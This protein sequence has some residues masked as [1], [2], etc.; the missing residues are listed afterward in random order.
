MKITSTEL[1]AKAMRQARKDQ[2]LSKA[3]IADRIGIKQATVSVFEN[4][5][6][7]SHLD[8]LFKWLS[9]LELDLQI[10]R[11]N[12]P[13]DKTQWDQEWQLGCPQWNT[14]LCSG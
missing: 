11:R 7:G 5:P 12:A 14:C 1:L 13:L 2:R 10:T 8:I 4:H 6:D 9:A 3:A